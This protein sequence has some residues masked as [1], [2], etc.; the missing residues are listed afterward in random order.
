[1]TIKYVK[2]DAT[3]PLGSGHK[4][5]THCC[6]DLGAWGAGFVLALSH[7]WPHVE[8]AYRNLGTYDLGDVQFVKATQMITVANII[9]Q[10]GVGFNYREGGAPIRYAAI[11]AGLRVVAY[12]AWFQFETI[13]PSTIHMPRMGCGL[14]GGSWDEMEPIIKRTLEGLD[15]TVYDF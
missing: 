12:R 1:M 8:K 13:K 5:I 14:A 2:G 9:G 7:K 6:N 3:A 11:E 4:I 15:V 10:H